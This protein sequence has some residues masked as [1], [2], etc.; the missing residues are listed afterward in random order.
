MVCRPVFVQIA[1]YKS[2]LTASTGT[3]F[4][5]NNEVKGKGS[6]KF[7]SGNA[8]SVGFKLACNVHVWAYFEKLPVSGKKYFFLQKWPMVLGRTISVINFL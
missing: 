3:F 6:P 1:L 5:E 2:N 8:D 7:V 4:W